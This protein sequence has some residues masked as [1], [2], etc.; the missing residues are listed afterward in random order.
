MFWFKKKPGEFDRFLE[1]EEKT[2]FT[3]HN[4]LFACGLATLCFMA[5]IFHKDEQKKWRGFVSENEC[6]VVAKDTSK[7]GP[8]SNTWKCK[9][10]ILYIKNANL[11]PFDVSFEAKE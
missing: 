8:D 5:W 3:K 1:N 4:L 6:K 2:I 7:L 11:G 10:G 9:D